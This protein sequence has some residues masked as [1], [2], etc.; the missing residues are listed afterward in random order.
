[1]LYRWAL[2]ASLS[3]R[4]GLWGGSV[5]WSGCTYQIPGHAYLYLVS[6]CNLKPTSNISLH[7]AQF[8]SVSHTVSQG[9]WESGTPGARLRTYFRM[10]RKGWPDGDRCVQPS[11]VTECQSWGPHGGRRE[12]TLSFSDHHVY[13]VAYNE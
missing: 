3:C 9:S 13:S 8:Q 12:P 4:L 1:M 5:L 10:N 7:P 6:C 2:L 11:L